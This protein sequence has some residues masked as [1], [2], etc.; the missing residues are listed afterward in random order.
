MKTAVNK[1]N[2]KIQC[3]QISVF[4]E[5][6]TEISAITVCFNVL[7]IKSARPISHAVFEWIGFRGAWK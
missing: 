3:A 2:G 6:C 1:L 5:Y 4:G 7:C